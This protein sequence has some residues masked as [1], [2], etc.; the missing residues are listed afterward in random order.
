MANA[1]RQKGT[2]GEHRVRV[3]V[4]MPQAEVDAIDEWALPAGMASRNAAVRL[5]VQ[6][7]LKAVPQTGLERFASET[8]ATPRIAG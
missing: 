7:G 2:R 3:V 6:E 4:E 1:Y 5:L 8:T